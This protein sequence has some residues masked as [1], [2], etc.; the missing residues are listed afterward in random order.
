M[1]R[2]AP[3][4]ETPQYIDSCYYY[5]RCTLLLP[6]HLRVE[7]GLSLLI[8]AR[9]PRAG[10]SLTPLWHPSAQGVEGCDGTGLVQAPSYHRACGFVGNMLAGTHG[11]PS[12]L[13]TPTLLLRNAYGPGA[14]SDAHSHP[15]LWMK[16]Q[17]KSPSSGKILNF[18]EPG[19]SHLQ[20]DI[21]R[22][23]ILCVQQDACY[24]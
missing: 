21:M 10:L 22:T 9:H 2:T 11:S 17:R 24:S 15:V 1:L 8:F 12:T 23:E 5:Y 6:S 18:S 16:K 14:F 13:H 3:Q 20:V 19:F 7:R 4:V